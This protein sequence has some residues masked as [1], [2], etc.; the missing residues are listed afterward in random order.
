MWVRSRAALALGKMDEASLATSVPDMADAFM[1]NVTAPLPWDP[2]FNTNDPLQMANGFL[3]GALFGTCADTLLN[4]DKNLLYQA[5]R[6]GL[7]Q[8]TGNCRGQLNGFVEYGLSQADVQALFPELVECAKVQ[9]PLDTFFSGYPPIAAMRAMSRTKVQEGIQVIN[10]NVPFYKSWALDALPNY[11]EAARWT[12][13]ELYAN[14]ANWQPSGSNYTALTNDISLLEAATSSSVVYALPHAN[15]QIGVTPA[16]TPKTIT[17]TGYSWRTAQ[18]TCIVASQPA[19]GTLTG[20]PPNLTYTPAAGYLGMDSFTFTAADGMITSTPATVNIVVGTGGS[21]LTG[22][23]YN[24]MDFTAFLASRTD[25]SVNFDWGSSP[26]NGLSA[27]TYSVRW[28]GQVLAPETGTYRFSTRTSDGVRLWINGVQ[29]INDWNDQAANL[30]ND[31]AAIT[32]TAGHQYHL[33]MEYYHKTNPATVRLYWYM[34]S[35]QSQAAMII[36]QELLYPVAGVCLTSPLDGARFGVPSGQTT[37]VTLT[38]DASDVVGTVANVSFYNGGTLIGTVATAPYSFPWTNVAVGEY[39]ITAR[40]TD[41]LGVVSTSAVASITVDS[42]TVPVTAGLACHF[43]A[44]VGVGTDANGAV[45]TWQDRSGNGHHATFDNSA[46]NSGTA[47]VAPNQIMSLPAVQVRAGWFDIAGKFFAK[48]QYVVVRSP[49]ATW[50]GTGAFI[51]RK[52]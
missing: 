25:S 38:A 31:S 5:V 1:T 28:A 45:K 20:Y 9:A 42:Y 4:A 47:T 15:P 37:T 11:G 13:P 14:L 43:D 2:G 49:T 30:W 48:E 46:W 16:N 34:P 41:S 17:L 27:G 19:H 3:A 10:D 6:V 52:S 36:P 21:G 29:V 40:A 24:N 33:E 51:G 12:L 44:S 7:Q 26:P 8:P 23:Y 35:R 22:S 39:D 18:V 50:S 32:L